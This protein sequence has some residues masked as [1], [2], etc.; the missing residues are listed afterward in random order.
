MTQERAQQNSIVMESR[1]QEVIRRLDS[2]EYIPTFLE[3]HTGLINFQST[4]EELTKKGPES[5][6]LKEAYK[7]GRILTITLSDGKLLGDGITHIDTIDKKS[8]ENHHLAPIQKI[9]KFL[10]VT[11]EELQDRLNIGNALVGEE[12]NGYQHPSIIRKIISS[13]EKRFVESSKTKPINERNLFGVTSNVDVV[14]RPDQETIQEKFNLAIK[15]IAEKEKKTEEQVGEEI[16][17]IAKQTD[18]HKLPAKVENLTQALGYILWS[19]KNPGGK[20]SISH[21]QT[22]DQIQEIFKFPKNSTKLGGASAQVSDIT[23]AI[24]EQKSTLYTQFHS[25]EQAKYHKYN[26]AFLR[27]DG[28]N[29]T[30][31]D[32]NT[33]ASLKDPTKTNIVFQIPPNTIIN[34][35]NGEQLIS[36]ESADRIIFPADGYLDNEGNKL[37]AKP[38]FDCNNELLGHL[39]EKENI[40]YFFLNGAQYAQRVKTLEEYNE[41]TA[42]LSSQLEQIQ[43]SGAIT[44][45]EFSGNK[46]R[47]QGEAEWAGIRFF[48][49][50][51][52]KIAS[53]GLGD[54]EVLP[55]VKSIKAELDPNIEIYD[56][57]NPDSLYK[58]G[59]TILR[60][61]EAQRVYI[62]GSDNDMVILDNSNN[63]LTEQDMEK[64]VNSCNHAK[65]KT[66]HHIKGD[67]PK[68]IV[69]NEEKLSKFIKTEGVSKISTFIKKIVKSFGLNKKESQELIS[70]ISEKGYFFHNDHAVAIIPIKW[71]YRQDQIVVTVS[72]GDITSYVSTL[73]SGLAERIRRN[74]TKNRTKNLDF[75]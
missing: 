29:Y 38:L 15:K 52:G 25:T 64:E 60:F 50:L 19:F 56:G 35:P 39:I 43:Q 8:Q 1:Q 21:K 20:V 11:P 3:T 40:S 18:A 33:S 4:I 70:Q 6:L 71:I 55:I 68:E 47:K 34:L 7:R 27:I 49:A 53:F 26:P 17:Q 69:P 28:D 45:F 42:E 44:H 72:S 61:F 54:N 65:D 23:A 14:I 30:I 24:G 16:S 22:I 74:K 41:F 10:N 59:L 51:R 9:A 31:G 75:I 36:K 62:H 5:E 32:I 66:T 48:E 57:E 46:E 63:Q 2:G 37:S 58:N 12:T 73:H 13:S 67:T